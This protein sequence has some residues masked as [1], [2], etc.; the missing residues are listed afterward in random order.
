MKKIKIDANPFFV[1]GFTIQS[2]GQV[3]LPVVEIT[4]IDFFQ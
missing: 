2:F 3:E 1:F 4:A